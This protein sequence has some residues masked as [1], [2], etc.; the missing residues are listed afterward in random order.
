[1]TWQV[2]GSF[3]RRHPSW[4]LYEGT[5][6]SAETWIDKAP[7]KTRSRKRATPQEIQDRK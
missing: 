4:A 2:I 5:D 1:M 6:S 3:I 7:K